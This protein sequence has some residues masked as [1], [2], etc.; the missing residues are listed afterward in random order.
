MPPSSGELLP[1]VALTCEHVSSMGHTFYIFLSLFFTDLNPAGLKG[2]N[3]GKCA[4]DKTPSLNAST[5]L[6]VKL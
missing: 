4:V 2:I 3:K 5:S 6:C 1:L